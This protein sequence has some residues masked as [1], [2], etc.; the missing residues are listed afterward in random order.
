MDKKDYVYRNLVSF[1]ETGKPIDPKTLKP[2]NYLFIL[3]KEFVQD[4]IYMVDNKLGKHSY[5]VELGNKYGVSEKFIRN[6]R[7]A[8]LLYRGQ[9]REKQRQ[10]TRQEVIESRDLLITR[11]RQLESEVK[12]LTYDIEKLYRL[13]ENR[14]STNFQHYNEVQTQSTFRV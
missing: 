1:L 4:I 9:I 8:L 3:T 11:N 14:N 13:L 10:E 12:R 5:Y 6:Y 7:D 2:K